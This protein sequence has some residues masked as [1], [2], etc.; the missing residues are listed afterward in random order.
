MRY[1][2]EHLIIRCDYWGVPILVPIWMCGHSLRSQL[3][4]CSQLRFR[5]SNR[6]SDS[7]HRHCTCSQENHNQSP[8]W[9]E[10]G[11][12]ANWV[13]CRSWS[14]W[15]QSRSKAGIHQGGRHKE[16][17]CHLREDHLENW[18]QQGPDWAC[19]SS[20]TLDCLIRNSNTFKVAALSRLMTNSSRKLYID[21][22][23]LL[24]SLHIPSFSISH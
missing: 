5:W 21:T 13:C 12:C 2:L 1:Q 16:W 18:D 3:W 15:W 24:S 22:S 11:Q 7:A 17:F 8:V 14:C 23:S 10:I 19:V 6:I 9:Q 20:A 4:V